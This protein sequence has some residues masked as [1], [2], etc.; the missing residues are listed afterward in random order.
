MIRFNKGD[1]LPFGARRFRKKTVVPMVGPMS[2]PFVCESREGEL[3]GQVGDFL[4]QDGHGGFY[5]ISAQFHAINYE[6]ADDEG[7][8][9]AK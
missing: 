4:A 1:A 8:E 9:A 3:C 6:L 2:E 5:P 7:R